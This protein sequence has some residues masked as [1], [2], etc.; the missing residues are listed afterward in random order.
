MST[1]VG[2]DVS[3]DAKIDFMN[4]N[5]NVQRDIENYNGTLN[6]PL[7]TNWQNRYWNEFRFVGYSFYIHWICSFFLKYLVDEIKDDIRSLSFSCC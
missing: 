2:L 5:A 4:K 1:W 7:F 6:S 3:P